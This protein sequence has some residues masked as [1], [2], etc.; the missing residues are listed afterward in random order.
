MKPFNSVEAQKRKATR[1]GKND[2]SDN[3]EME[4]LDEGALDKALEGPEEL[5]TK[6]PGRQLMRSSMINT[7]K[8][9]MLSFQNILY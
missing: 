8:N 1:K 4:I 9:H 2:K 5:F 6:R 3:F 7:S